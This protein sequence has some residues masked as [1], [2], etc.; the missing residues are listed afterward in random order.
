MEREG[1]IDGGTAASQA[2]IKAGTFQRGAA[3]MKQTGDL[4]DERQCKLLV[5]IL[6]MDEKFIEMNELQQLCR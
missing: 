6:R 1:D 2:C 5:Q 4:E 3:S